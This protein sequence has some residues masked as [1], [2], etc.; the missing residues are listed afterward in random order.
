M[1]TCTMLNII[2]GGL[3]TLSRTN[4][5]IDPNGQVVAKLFGFIKGQLRA[6]AY[7]RPVVEA[8]TIHKSGRQEAQKILT[9]LYILSINKF[10]TGYIPPATGPLSLS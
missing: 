7:H 2:N 10:H 4:S 9:V 3:G 6:I 1:S 8:K 5:F